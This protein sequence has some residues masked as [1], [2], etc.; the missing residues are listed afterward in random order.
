M[1]VSSPG[2]LCAVLISGKLNRHRDLSQLTCRLEVVLTCGCAP[3]EILGFAG[4]G[5]S[6]SSIYRHNRLRIDTRMHAE[7]GKFGDTVSTHHLSDKTIH[8]GMIL[9]LL[10]HWCDQRYAA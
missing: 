4:P 7:E 5:C 3:N 8:T 1:T 6:C 9:T 10:L 2:N